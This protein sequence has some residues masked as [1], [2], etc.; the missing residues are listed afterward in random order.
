MHS[1]I[2]KTGPKLYPASAPLAE[3]LDECGG[4]VA[5]PAVELGRLF[6][7]LAAAPWDGDKPA[8]QF[9]QRRH[10]SPELFELRYRQHILLTFSPA[11]FD[12]LKGNV[13]GNRAERLRILLADVSVSARF[14]RVRP[15][16]AVNL[17]MSI[18]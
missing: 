3:R 14:S 4:A 2:K 13:S 16:N 18:Q 11:F 10:V 8:G 9:R 7:L 5:Q 15:N 6:E 17:S 12:V 1:Y